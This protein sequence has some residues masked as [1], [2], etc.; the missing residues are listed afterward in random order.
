[1]RTARSVPSGYLHTDGAAVVAADGTVVRL[2]GVNWYGME[3][4]W[5]VP[6]GLDLRTI[7]EVCDA[8][9][10]LGFDHIRLP[11]SDEVVRFNP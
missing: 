5:T 10:A 6:G 7:D 1:M 9:A 11:Y 2:A 4:E 8:I 3:C